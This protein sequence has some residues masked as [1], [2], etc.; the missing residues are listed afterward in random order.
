VTVATHSAG[1]SAG[2]G[3]PGDVLGIVEG[4]VQ[5]AGSDVTAV[6]E[7]VLHRLLGGGGELVTVVTGHDAPRGL[8]P[9]LE[10]VVASG[11]PEVDVLVHEGGQAGYPVLVAVE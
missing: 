8:G 5:L 4:E 1:T 11:H 2:P 10:A 9:R 7:Q 3:K 6:A